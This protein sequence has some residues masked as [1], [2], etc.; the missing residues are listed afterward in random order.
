MRLLVLLFC[1]TGTVLAAPFCLWKPPGDA[2]PERYLNL[3]V[4]QYVDYVDN[5][6]RVSYGGGNLGSGH[7]VKIAV[8]GR[9]EALKILQDMRDS[10]R[11]CDQ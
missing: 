2:K 6:L 8:K 4:V 5:E 10:A 7:E 3:T 9:E 1:C 11:R